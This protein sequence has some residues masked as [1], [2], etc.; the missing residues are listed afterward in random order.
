[1]IAHETKGMDP[2]LVSLYSLLQKKTK[3]NSVNIRSE[4]IL[5]A[6]ATKHDMIQCARKMNTR[7]ASHTVFLPIKYQNVK[8]DPDVIIPRELL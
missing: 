1:M 3:A 5:A 4:N 6:I 7:F 2:M 8:P